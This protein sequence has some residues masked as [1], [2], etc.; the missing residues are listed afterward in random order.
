MLAAMRDIE[1]DSR[2]MPMSNPVME[3]VN[4][5]SIR[6]TAVE[7]KAINDP[8]KMMT[9]DRRIVKH[10]QGRKLSVDRDNSPIWVYLYQQNA[11]ER[12]PRWIKP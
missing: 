1:R 6:L 2:R 11:L 8:K 5:P 3:V 7:L 4:D 12:K 10:Q 9:S